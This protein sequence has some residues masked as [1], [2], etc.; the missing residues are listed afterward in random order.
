MC[1]HVANH[2]C[3]IAMQKGMMKENEGRIRH[4][5]DNLKIVTQD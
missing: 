2:Y 4:L 3:F 5:H 1:G